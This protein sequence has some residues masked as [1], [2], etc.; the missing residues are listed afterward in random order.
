MSSNIIYIAFGSKEGED[1]KGGGKSCGKDCRDD[2]RLCVERRHLSSS[3]VSGGGFHLQG[4]HRSLVDL[5]NRKQVAQLLGIPEGKL[6]W[7]ERCGLVTPSRKY[8]REKF[9]T[10]ENLIAVRAA[11][12]LIDRGCKAAGIKKAIRKLCE[13]IPD[14]E[15]P[16]TRMKVCGND[17]RLVIE[18]EGKDVEVESGQILIDFS[19]SSVV[20]EIKEAV[21][22]GVRSAK[23]RGKTGYDWFL[24]GVTIEDASDPSTWEAAETAYHKALEL[25]PNLAPAL[26]NLGNIKFRQNQIKMAEEFYKRAIRID[27]CLPQPHY[28]LGCMKL[29]TGRS[30]LAMVYLKKAHELDPEF[31]DVYFNMAL[32]LEKE[33]RKKEAVGNFMKF[34]ELEEDSSWSQIAREHIKKLM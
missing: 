10:F 30:D 26:T 1:D 5:Y 19:V 31:A 13:Q 8:G 2:E 23:D 7:W 20:K 32:A 12:E 22:S 18:R 28:N 6:K 4:E 14:A 15:K 33:G 27:P 29:K 16:L 17:R 24:E 9:Y 34:L 25:E 11:K 3:H 21:I